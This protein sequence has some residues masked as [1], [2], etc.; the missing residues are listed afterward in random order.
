MCLEVLDVLLDNVEVIIKNETSFSITISTSD[1]DVEIEVEPQE[2]LPFDIYD[3]A[4]SDGNY[5]YDEASKPSLSHLSKAE[6]I[7]LILDKINVKSSDKPNR[8]QLI[9]IV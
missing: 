1:K 9:E 7:R 8:K 5:I 4:D 3:Y 6:P 2:L